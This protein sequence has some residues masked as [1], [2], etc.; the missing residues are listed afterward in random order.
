MYILEVIIVIFS[1]YNRKF[2]YDAWFFLFCCCLVDMTYMFFKNKTLWS[3]VIGKLSE[4]R[5]VLLRG[6]GAGGQCE[7][8]RHWVER[9]QMS[10]EGVTY[11]ISPELS[12]ICIV[13]H[14]GLCWWL[15]Y[16]I[17][18]IVV[19]GEA[20]LQLHSVPCTILH[21]LSSNEHVRMLI[22]KTPM[23]CNG[24]GRL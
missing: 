24:N 4:A 6:S 23:H 16:M 9:P 1:T 2:L 15:N 7:D 10:P 12:T 5:S 19:L 3:F 13:I 11:Q 20:T 17:C 21:N 18:L 8:C 14:L 22:K